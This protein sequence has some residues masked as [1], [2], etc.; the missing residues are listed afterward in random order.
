M[1]RA[2]KKKTAKAPAPKA[3]KAARAPKAPKD[4]KPKPEKWNV[5]RVEKLLLLGEYPGSPKVTGA[6]VAALVQAKLVQ[7]GE[8][9]RIRRGW[10]GKAAALTAAGRGY[11]ARLSEA[12]VE[13]GDK[14]RLRQKAEAARVLAVIEDKAVAGT[15]GVF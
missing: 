12:L 2:S 8:L 10:S 6:S 7:V 9:S 11:L 5:A 15:R 1:A 4:D 3:P 13:P 14:D